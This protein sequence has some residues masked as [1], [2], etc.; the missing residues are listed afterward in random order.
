MTC[1]LLCGEIYHLLCSNTFQ[2]ELRL[3]LMIKIRKFS[4][5]CWVR[6]PLYT[7]F[8]GRRYSLPSR[9]TKF[10]LCTDRK[11]PL[12]TDFSE[13]RHYQA[14]TLVIPFLFEDLPIVH[15][16]VNDQSLGGERSVTGRWTMERWSS[17]DGKM[18]IWERQIR[19]SK[20]TLRKDLN[21]VA[22]RR[23]DKLVKISTLTTNE[24]RTR[25]HIKARP[26]WRKKKRRW[27]QEAKHFEI[28]LFFP[29]FAAYLTCNY[30]Q[31][32]RIKD[33][34]HTKLENIL[35]NLT[36]IWFCFFWLRRRASSLLR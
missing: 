8:S 1:P 21:N 5:R 23:T 6:K 24:L 31:P 13:L 29:N 18:Y 12:R 20:T 15:W 19:S 26:K 14:K 35:Q 7:T 32:K 28:P 22:F 36:T 9:H 27:K 34:E 10:P 11:F 3:Y 2:L 30:P 16:A 25:I 17:V 4:L 33:W